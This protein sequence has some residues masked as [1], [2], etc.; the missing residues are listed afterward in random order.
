MSERDLI[1][2]TPNPNTLASLTAELIALG[3]ARGDTLLVHAS[4][5]NI[6]WTVG[7]ARTVIEALF[8][9]VGSAGTICMP[10]PQRAFKRSRPVGE[11]AGPGGLGSRH[12]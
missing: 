2:R 5:S 9:A 12:L 8:N 11:S 3:V 1:S 10:A 4:L 6:G 7:G